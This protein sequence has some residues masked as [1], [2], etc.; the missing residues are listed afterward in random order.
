MGGLGGGERDVESILYSFVGAESLNKRIKPSAG[1][2]A[3]Q[4]VT[5]NERG[6]CKPVARSDWSLLGQRAEI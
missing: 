3:G 6:G 1:W 4:G 2:P 5:G